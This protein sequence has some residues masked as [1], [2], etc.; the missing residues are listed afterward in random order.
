MPNE[1]KAVLSAGTANGLEVYTLNDE[2][3]TTFADG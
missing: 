3:V 2:Y 1:R